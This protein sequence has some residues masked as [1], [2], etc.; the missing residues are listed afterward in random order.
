MGDSGI[1]RVGARTVKWLC[2]CLLYPFLLAGARKHSQADSSACSQLEVASS[3][4][5]VLEAKDFLG[6]SILQDV[7]L[8]RRE[9]VPQNTET[10]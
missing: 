10:M 2:V 5:W 8:A 3:Q 9:V 7:L 1:I 6:L 4:P